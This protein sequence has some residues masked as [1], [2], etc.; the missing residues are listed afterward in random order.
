MYRAIMGIDRNDHR[1]GTYRLVA[2][3]AIFLVVPRAQ[4]LLRCA[5]VHTGRKLG[6]VVPISVKGAGSSLH[7]VAWAEAYP[8]IKWHPNPSNRLA[9]IHQSYRQDRQTDRRWSDSAGRTVSQT[10]AHKRMWARLAGNCS[11]HS[12]V[13][14]RRDTLMQR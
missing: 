6:A 5:T 7:S 14:I 2:I 4:Q 9:T 3:G 10:V 11:S 13:V 1:R 12:D 8:H